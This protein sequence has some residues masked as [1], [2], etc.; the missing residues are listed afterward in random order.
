MSNV[1][2]QA[3]VNFNEEKPQDK[4]SGIILELGG[5]NLSNQYERLVH[6]YEMSS[7][8][9]ERDREMMA[10]IGSVRLFTSTL[11]TEKKT[12]A[13]VFSKANKA[14]LK[15]PVRNGFNIISQ[16][17][18]I[19]YINN[20]FTQRFVPQFRFDPI[21]NSIVIEGGIECW[22]AIT[23]EYSTEYSVYVYR[24]KYDSVATVQGVFTGNEEVGTIFSRI[25]LA[26]TTLDM[27]PVQA[28]GRTPKVEIYRVT[29]EYIAT[30]KGEMEMPPNF[31]ENRVHDNGFE[32]PSKNNCIIQGRT[33]EIVSL[34]GVE[35]SSYPSLFPPYNGANVFWRPKYKFTKA[36]PPQGYSERKTHNHLTWEDR[37]WEEL[38]WD[39]IKSGV[40]DRFPDIEIKD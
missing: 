15:Y 32:V 38:D 3:T 16:S 40:R 14:T 5:F 20:A 1:V 9:G 10:T 25:G 7:L 27:P 21:E 33:H 36:S 4:T 19:G 28:W 11:K 2:A 6:Q 12:E 31:P 13:V 39:A 17:S 29:S 34:G 37:Q 18:F 24:A 23:V 35:Y 30:P 26:M 22:G 8:A